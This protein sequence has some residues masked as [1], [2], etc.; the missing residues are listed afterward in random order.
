MKLPLSK[1]SS[2]SDGP[3]R[4]GVRALR[5]GLTI[6]I[7]SAACYV[8]YG[9]GRLWHDWRQASQLR[10][11]VNTSQP[12]ALL[13]DA[14]PLAGQWMFGDLDWS[15]RSEAIEPQAVMTRFA[16]AAADAR[17]SEVDHLPDLNPQW[18]DVAQHLQVRPVTRDGNQIYVLDQT[19]LKAQL[20][21]REVAGHIKAISLAA[22]FP[23]QSAAWRLYEFTPNAR[24]G[25]ANTKTAHLL[26]LS[27]NAKRLGGRFT[28]DGQLLLELVKVEGGAD[29]L[30][31][32]W[33][34]NG[35]E[36]HP[37]EFAGPSDF[38][39]LCV[40]KNEV[41]YAWSADR[42]ASLQNLM[43]LRSSAESDIRPQ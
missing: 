21:V 6:T 36:V 1:M 26:P 9:F 33:S 14:P 31:S 20:I 39:Y 16:A 17:H 32:L 12:L 38:S 37:T 11:G 28:N 24:A 34:A 35:W 40:Q 15:L 2:K 23:E 42:R 41:I 30:L 43:L 27:V 4:R 13:P 19:N 10:A 25:D 22:A 7:V 29:Q 18:I 3:R 5:A 8:S